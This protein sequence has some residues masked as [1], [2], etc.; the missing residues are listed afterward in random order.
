MVGGRRSSDRLPR[1]RRAPAPTI[2]L[3]LTALYGTVFLITGAALLTVGYVFVRTNLRTHHS[4]RA[5]LIRLGIRPVRGEF[6]FPPGSSTGKLIHAVQNQILGGALHRLLIE[7]AVALVAMTAISVVI[8]WLLAGR[9]LAPLREITATARRVSS[10]NLGER[11]DLPGP[12]DELRELADTFDGML[13]RLDGAFA[14]QRHFVANA[15]HELRTPL[16]IMRTE[17]DVALADPDA[18][19][20]ELREMGEAVRDTVDRCERLIASLLLLARS[21]AATGQEEPVDIGA[22]AAD[23]ITDL[24][25]RAEEAQIEIRD[26]LEPAWTSGHP[27][28]LERLIANLVDNGIH[29]NVPGGFLQVQTRALG[30]EVEVVVANG[31]DPIDPKRVRELVEPF[32]RLDRSVRGF[33]LGLSIVR[34]IA[35]AHHGTAILLAPATGGLEV[36]VTLPRLSESRA[37]RPR[38][39]DAV[40]SANGGLSADPQNPLTKS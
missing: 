6:G 19:V 10:E 29:H 40:R 24:W 25:A 26:D 36:R 21:E 17:V 14:S 30:G 18:S 5:E 35:Q 32:R 11:I 23:C 2:R 20:V 37:T 3:R 34:S 22:L 9:A 39:T 31:G 16:A 28:L 12:A 13:G 33:G 38:P 4:L 7:Y 8:G 27:G 15:S 1:Q